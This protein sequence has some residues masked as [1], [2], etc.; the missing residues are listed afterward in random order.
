MRR[1]SGIFALL[2]FAGSYVTG[3][4]SE[5]KLRDKGKAHLTPFLHHPMDGRISV[6]NVGN[7]A[8]APTKLTLDCVKLG[9]PME[10]NSCPNL[11][12]SVARAYFDPMFPKNATIQVPALAPGETFTHS[13]SFWSSFRWPAGRYKFTVVADASHVVSDQ[14]SKGSV[15]TS[16]LVVP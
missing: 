2:I 11:P 1:V 14:P 3:Q 12:L 6:T 10:M 4:S 15:A 5:Y 8:S 9:T 13:L 7:G 16:T